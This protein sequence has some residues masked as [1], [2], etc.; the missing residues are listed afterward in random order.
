MRRYFLSKLVTR[1][2][3]EENY[4]ELAIDLQ[5]HADGSQFWPLGTART[6]ARAPGQN[7]GLTLVDVSQA[8][9]LFMNPSG[10]PV[11]DP[12]GKPVTVPLLLPTVPVPTDPNVYAM[13][14]HGMDTKI[15]TIHLPTLM[16]LRTFIGA[17][18]LD[19][20]IIDNSDG[21]RSL[22]RTL[23]RVGDPGFD[24]NTFGQR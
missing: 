8:F 20:N 1:T 7:W 19:P 10:S 18:G 6:H 16:S 14:E 3:D 11:L 4:T 2:I 12:Q 5:F 24:E 21:Y 15:S 13:P 22:I 9:R 17:I 23:G